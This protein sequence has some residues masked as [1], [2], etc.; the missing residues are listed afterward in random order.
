MLWYVKLPTHISYH[1][2]IC[3]LSDSFFRFLI[4]RTMILVQDISI[5]SMLL[6]WVRYE[7]P[8]ISDGRCLTN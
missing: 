1:S 2:L 8:I 4:A 7:S 3:F 6:S 5:W